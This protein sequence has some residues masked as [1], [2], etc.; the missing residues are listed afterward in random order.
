MQKQ[1]PFKAVLRQPVRTL[2]FLLLVGLAT[3]GFVSRV[4]E[5]TVLSREINRIEAFYQTTGQLVPLD[6]INHNNLYQAVQ[7]IQNSPLIRT[8]DI[9]SITQ[10][11]MHETNNAMDGFSVD[12]I[13]LLQG[14]RTWRHIGANIY[15]TVGIIYVNHKMDRYTTI[16]DPSMPPGRINITTIRIEVIDVLHG[17]NPFHDMRRYLGNFI[18]SEMGNKLDHVVEGGMY[19]VNMNYHGRDTFTVSFFPLFDDVYF[20]DATDHEALNYARRRMADELAVIDV[21][22]HLLTLTGTKDMTTLPF[23]Q[24]GSIERFQGRFFSYEDYL[25]RNHVMVVPQALDSGRREARVGEIVTLTLR[26]MRTFLNGA[27]NP[28][29]GVNHIADIYW[30]NLPAGYWTAIPYHQNTDWHNYETIEIQVEIIGTYT[31]HLAPRWGWGL[32][33]NFATI[34]AFVP[35]SIIPEGFGIVDY[36]IVSGQYSFMLNDPDG[37]VQ[38][39]ARYGTALEGL[40]VRAEFFGEDSTNFMLSAIP[41]RNSINVNL[42]LFSIVF[43]IVVATTVFL[44]LRQRYKEFAIMRALGVSTPRAIGRVLLPIVVLWL[45]ITIGASIGAWFFALSQVADSLQILAQ[46]DTPFDESILRPV[47]NILQMMRYEAYLIEVRMRP[48]IDI[49]YLV[50]ICVLGVTMWLAAVSIGTAVF[51]GKSMISL[52]QGVNTAGGVMP[53]LKEVLPSK[54]KL[55]NIAD[56]LMMQPALYAKNKIKATMTHHRRHIFRAPVKYSLV[57]AMALLFVLATGWLNHTINVTQQEV[58]RLYATTIISG[59]VIDPTHGMAGSFWGFEVTMEG[60]EILLNSGAVENITTLTTNTGLFMQRYDEI[61]PQDYQVQNVNTIRNMHTHRIISFCTLDRF[62]YEA[63][64]PSAFGFGQNIDF[65]INFA[66]WF[67]YTQFAPGFDLERMEDEWPDRVPLVVHEDFMH[68]RY[69]IDLG[70][71][72]VTYHYLED[73]FGIS[74][75]NELALGDY[76]FVMLMSPWGES[77]FHAQIVGTYRGGHPMVVQGAPTLMGVNFNVFSH[78]RFDMKQDQLPYLNS[79][80]EDINY[81]FNRIERQTFIQ[82]AGGYMPNNQAINMGITLHDAEFRVVIM[83]LEESLNLL[84]ILYPIAQIMSFVLALGVCLLLMLQNAK[85]VAIMRVLGT[86]KQKARFNFTL[87]QIVVC[88]TGAIVGALAIFII[89]VSMI[90]T[91]KLFGIYLGGAVIGTLIGVIVISAKTPIELLQVKE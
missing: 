87:E 30:P 62:I 45:P 41:I 39:L 9:R 14:E 23:V 18:T 31:R 60:I 46:I 10:A 74:R 1:I 91:A 79:F 56:V 2:I 57:L 27:P 52:L 6:P 4:V 22:N 26:D 20:V 90:D 71:E 64:R 28:N 86:P 77:I 35:A 54:L 12:S 82:G 38:F 16:M 24:A 67:D 76:V 25:E 50:W 63:S 40:G 8:H 19:L 84:M 49:A 17:K 53:S 13:G 15:D 48:D 34:E 43:V 80:V 47:M 83:P 88:L 81:Q 21:N 85:Y 51:A 7:L 5:H 73:D 58:D 36:H 3:F 42:L 29:P 37:D 11:T 59:E 72:F 69:F 65:E 78:V 32:C 70:G 33:C 68:T 89:G 66:P 75:W 61:D 55:T 44:Y